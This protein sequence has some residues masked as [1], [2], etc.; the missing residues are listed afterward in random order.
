[1]NYK[2]LLKAMGLMFLPTLSVLFIML[3][4][5]FDFT[6]MKDFIT[7]NSGWAIFLR[8]LLV[9]LEVV[10]V[11]Y[12]YLHYSKEDLIKNPKKNGPESSLYEFG[13]KLT[14]DQQYKSKVYKTTLSNLFL[15]EKLG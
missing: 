11:V 7:S 8:I 13:Q 3:V 9:L 2:I 15:I 1:M 4:G 5:F 14:R 10:C 6:A 12:L